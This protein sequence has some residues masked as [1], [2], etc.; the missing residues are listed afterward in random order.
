MDRRGFLAAMLAACAA[1]AIVRAGSIMRAKPI[2][3]PPADWFH[4]LETWEDLAGQYTVSYWSKGGQIADYGLWTR[5]LSAEE[6]LSLQ[7]L[8][9]RLVGAPILWAPLNG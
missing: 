9:A 7:T 6:V 2:I 5:A 8:S 4:T 1:P 3:L